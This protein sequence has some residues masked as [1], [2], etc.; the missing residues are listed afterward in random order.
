METVDE[1]VAPPADTDPA[2]LMGALVTNVMRRVYSQVEAEVIEECKVIG[3]DP[4]PE[5]IQ[6]T[7]S[8]NRQHLEEFTQKRQRDVL[9][10]IQKEVADLKKIETSEPLI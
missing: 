6:G 9:E 8:E 2:D 4:T 1:K 3:V 7:T 10:K 5:G